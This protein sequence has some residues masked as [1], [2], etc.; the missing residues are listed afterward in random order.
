MKK[1]FI[2]LASVFL[3]AGCA[4]YIAAISGGAANGK[5]TQS[6]VRSAASYGIKK[7]TGNTLLGHAFERI[8]KKSPEKKKTCSTFSNN[9]DLEICLMVEKRIISQQVKIKD[10]EFSYK[11]SK[12]LTSALQSSINEKSKIKYLD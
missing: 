3:L 5:F 12:E 8:K 7:T 1:I 2:L 10:K 11:S 9:K 4:E 6:T